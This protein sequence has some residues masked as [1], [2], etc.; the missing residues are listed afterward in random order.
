MSGM[1][2]GADPFLLGD[3]FVRC[4]TLLGRQRTREVNQWLSIDLKII[5]ASNRP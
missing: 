3:R 5:D 1:S 2:D 4:S